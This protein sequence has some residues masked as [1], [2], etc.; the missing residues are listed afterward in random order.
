M[1]LVPTTQQGKVN[2]FK[3]KIDPWT[4]S[5]T[6]I[7]TTVTEVTAL[8]GLADAAQ[9]AITA[10]VVAQAAAK[11]AAAEADQAVAALAKAGAD[12]ISAIRTKART[13]GDEV[14]NLAQIP[15]P[16]HRTPK[17]PP[18]TPD[19]FTATLTT[20]GTLKLGWE[21]Q[22]PPG[23]SGTLYHVYRQISAESPFVFLGGS[24]VKSFVDQTVPPGSTRVTYQIQAVRGGT[25]SEFGEFNVNFSKSGVGVSFNSNPAA[26]LAA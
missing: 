16:A 18:G 10:R 21:C 8:D 22:N 1:S 3:G 25:A 9:K 11:T 14:Y 7:G 17:Q 15:A 2:F 5:A 23:V 12:I 6:A 24:N 19:K 13:G 26:K 4:A 20:S